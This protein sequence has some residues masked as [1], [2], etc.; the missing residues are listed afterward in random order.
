M[1]KYVKDILRSTLKRKCMANVNT[2]VDIGTSK[3]DQNEASYLP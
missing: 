1:K 2:N 3:I